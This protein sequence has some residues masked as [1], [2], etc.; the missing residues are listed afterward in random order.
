MSCHHYRKNSWGVI[1]EMCDPQLLNV[2]VASNTDSGNL[3][4]FL[5]IAKMHVALSRKI[6][7]VTNM[8]EK[9][10]CSW[11]GYKFLM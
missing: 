3:F 6:F 1:Y 7:L 11:W 10:L 8:S 5:N 2:F 9:I 4:V